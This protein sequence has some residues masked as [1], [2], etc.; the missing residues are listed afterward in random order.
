MDGHGTIRAF[1]QGFHDRLPWL[2]FVMQS[3]LLFS[4]ILELGESDIVAVTETWLTSNI[5]DGK[6]FSDD[7]MLDL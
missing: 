1:P 7:Y 6:L 5:R 3:A 2:L 4:A